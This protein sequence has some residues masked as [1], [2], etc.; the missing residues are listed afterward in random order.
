MGISYPALCG[1]LPACSD[2]EP[3]SDRGLAGNPSA[4]F[5]ATRFATV[6]R[7]GFVPPF[8]AGRNLCD[9]MRWAANTG[10]LINVIRGCAVRRKIRTVSN[11]GER[12]AMTNELEK[13]FD[14]AMMDV[15]C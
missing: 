9:H 4:W 14:E 12:D 5:T 15:Y 8:A 3:G 2:S 7:L 13:R 1:H 11:L 10:F 6:V